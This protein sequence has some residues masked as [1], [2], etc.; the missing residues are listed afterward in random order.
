MSPFGVMVALAGP[1]PLETGN[2]SEWA[3]S[4]RY[5]KGAGVPQR[6]FPQD[7]KLQQPCKSPGFNGER[8]C[9]N[10]QTYVA[11]HSHVHTFVTR[12]CTVMIASIVASIPTYRGLECVVA[13][14]P[15]E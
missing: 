5:R 12:L 11:V 3:Q 15:V 10:S 7:V 8:A 9:D 14:E 13:P 6:T 1:D 2:G 4:V